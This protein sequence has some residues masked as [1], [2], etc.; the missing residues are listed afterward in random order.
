MLQQ[1]PVETIMQIL[2]ELPLGI[3]IGRV[4]LLSRVFSAILLDLRFALIHVRRQVLKYVTKDIVSRGAALKLVARTVAPEFDSI[5]L[6]YKAAL[7]RELFV[8][9]APV[10]KPSHVEVFALLKLSSGREAAHLVQLLIAH[11][12][13]KLITSSK[14]CAKLSWN[15]VFSW[16]C[17][18]GHADAVPLLLEKVDPSLNNCRTFQLAAKYGHTNVLTLLLQH[19][20]INPSANNNA[21][22]RLASR[23]GHPESLSLLLSDSRTDAATNSH[24]AFRRACEHN[25]ISCAKLLLFHASTN[26]AAQDNY[27]IVKA[28]EHGHTEMIRLLLTHPSIDPCSRNNLPLRLTCTNGHFEA[29]VALL[30]HPFVDPSVSENVCLNLACE[31]GHLNIVNH[32]LMDPRC[33]PTETCLRKAC[34]NNHA[35]IVEQLL[36]DSRVIPSDEL[37]R[38][39]CNRGYTSILCILLHDGRCNPSSGL[40]DAVLFGFLDNVKLLCCDPRC[41]FQSVDFTDI[42]QGN[43]CLQFV[44]GLIEEQREKENEPVNGSE[45]TLKETFGEPL[46]K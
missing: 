28:A 44:K 6:S 23:H 33:S 41:N 38:I 26:P 5:P 20:K 36:S 30:M 45:D 37:L 31:H 15:V 40:R 3:S 19:P 8:E 24:S 34:E 2:C 11:E 17:R 9:F 1:L 43:A 32:L 46:P 35:L 14:P 10:S 39:A 22:L 18:F 12:N 7:L 16:V 21:S 25:H 27:A 29:L 13:E 42:D 4:L